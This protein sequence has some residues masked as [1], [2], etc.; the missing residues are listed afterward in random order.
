MQVIQ[1]AKFTDSIIDGVNKT[2]CKLHGFLILSSRSVDDNN[3][4]RCSKCIA[5]ELGIKRR[6]KKLN[7]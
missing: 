2:I 1:R 7:K 4:V 6:L 3:I 5:R